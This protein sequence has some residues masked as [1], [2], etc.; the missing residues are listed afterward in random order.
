MSHPGVLFLEAHTRSALTNIPSCVG[1]HECPS[2]ELTS[3]WTFDGEARGSLSQTR[4]VGPRHELFGNNGTPVSVF[5]QQLG[6]H[7][8]WTCAR[9]K[10]AWSCVFRAQ[11]D[12][13][14]PSERGPALLAVQSRRGPT[15]TGLA[16]GREANNGCM[17]SQRV[18]VESTVSPGSPVWRRPLQRELC[19]LALHF[20][21]IDRPCCDCGR[22]GRPGRPQH[23][24][25][26]NL[27]AEARPRVPEHC[28]R[29]ALVH[30][31]C[32]C[33]AHWTLSLV[34]WFQLSG[35]VCRRACRGA[36]RCLC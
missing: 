30:A 33:L 11:I 6:R 1:D 35:T 5:L 24:Q 19:R 25:H 27:R 3:A 36:I 16:S 32:R 10:G 23:G 21:H 29:T 2:P 31:L 12:A 9:R 15:V 4:P 28:G 13:T 17:S 8:V 20:E 14:N 18:H 34:C 22:H 26:R 7:D